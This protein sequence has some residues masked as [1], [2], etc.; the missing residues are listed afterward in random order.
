[1]RFAKFISLA[2][3]VAVLMVLSAGAQPPGPPGGKAAKGNKKGQNPDSAQLLDELKLT[4]AQRRK[5]R[6]ILRAHDDRLREATRKARTELLTEMKGV[7]DEVAYKSFKEELDQVPLLPG[8]PANLR[9]I[10]ADDLVERL[11]GFDKNGDGKVT[12]DELPERMHALIEQGDRNNDG[13]LDRDEMRRL[14]ER[15]PQGKDGGPKGGFPK[16]GLPKGGFPKDG[17]PKGGKNPDE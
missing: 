6:D 1:M 8:V 10:A 16:D 13:A 9:T 15:G 3:G 11:M 4:D 5:A 17:F 2:A 12:R 14:S 7:L